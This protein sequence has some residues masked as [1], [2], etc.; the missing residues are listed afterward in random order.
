MT[1]Q[2]MEEWFEQYQDELITQLMNKQYRPMPVK[3]VYISK[4]NGKKRPRGIP[5][6]ADRVIQ[7]AMAQIL[8][9]IYEPIFSEH[10]YGFR[11]NRSAHMVMEEVLYYLNE[12]YEW[13]SRLGYRKIL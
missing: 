1:V 9:T 4:L 5:T 6:V 13:N 10:S 3:R 8:T 7:Q 2:E 12:G 11:S